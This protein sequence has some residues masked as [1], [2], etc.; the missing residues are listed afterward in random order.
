MPRKAIK[1]TI[2]EHYECKSCGYNRVEQYP[3][4]G[5]LQHLKHY[6]KV[7]KIEDGVY[8]VHVKFEGCDHCLPF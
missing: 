1:K 8:S 5:P 3:Y 6:G 2:Q 4:D 7:R